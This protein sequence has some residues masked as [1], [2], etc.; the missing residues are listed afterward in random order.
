VVA[1]AAV[2][3][4]PVAEIVEEVTAVEAP[5]VEVEAAPE[6]KAETKSEE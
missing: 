4:A 5:A 3:E 6:V 2:V 1:E